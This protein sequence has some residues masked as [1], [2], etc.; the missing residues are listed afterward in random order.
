MSDNVKLVQGL[1][2]AFGRGEIGT[3]A[4]AMT[5]DYTWRVAGEKMHY[6][7]A[8][9]WRGANGVTEFFSLVAQTQ[10]ALE[11]SPREFY[12][13]EDRVFVLGHYK[14]KLKKNGKIAEADFVHIFTVKDGKVS[15]FAEF[16]DTATFAEAYRG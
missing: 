2:A 15:A 1:Y 13:A 5:A 6:P 3:I 7:T 16:T 14:W 11:F 9:V 10:D 12:A 8:G 4:N